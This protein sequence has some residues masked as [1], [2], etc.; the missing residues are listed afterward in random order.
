PQ[1]PEVLPARLAGPTAGSP[2]ARHTLTIPNRAPLGTPRPTNLMSDS[3]ATSAPSADTSQ[4][5]PASVRDDFPILAQPVHGDK[6]LV[7]LD[8]AASSQ[9]PRQVIDAVVR[10]YEHDYANV[11]RGIHVLSE[12]ATD[13][14]EQARRKV[15]KFIG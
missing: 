11:H 3:V 9:R 10:C 4:L 13:G 8:S 5:L 15:Q 7:F 1:P 2:F 12:R 6:P 14:Y